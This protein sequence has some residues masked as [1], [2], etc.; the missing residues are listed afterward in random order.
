MATAL[1]T[2]I[3]YAVQTLFD[4]A[5]TAGRLVDLG[6]LAN[7]GLL[8]SFTPAYLFTAGVNGTWYDPSDITTLYRD[9]A[10][11]IPVT[12]MEQPVG[13][14]LDKSKGAVPGANVSD[15]AELTTTGT[16]STTLFTATTAGWYALSANIVSGTG[17]TGW[18]VVSPAYTGPKEAAGNSITA[19]VYVNAGSAVQ[20]SSSSASSLRTTGIAVQALAGNHA[21]NPSGNSA[22]FPVLSARYNLLTKTEDFSDGVWNATSGNVTVS[23]GKII[24]N[25][26]SGGHYVSQGISTLGVTHTITAR[27]KQAGYTWIKLVAFNQYANFDLANGVVGTNYSGVSRTISAVG[28]GSYIC[29]F[30]FTSTSAASNQGCII[31]VGTADNA[32]WDSA[33][34]SGNGVDGIQIYYADLRVANDAL[35]QPAYQRVN[36]S[37]DYDTVGFKPYLKFNGVNQWLQTNSIDFSYTDKM[38]VSVGGR[39]LGT[40]GAAL[41]ELSAIYSTNPAFAV[42]APSTLKDAYGARSRGT[43]TVVLDADGTQPSPVTTVFSVVCSISG[44]L[45]SLRLDGVQDAAST[46][47]QGTGNYGNYPLYIGARAGTSLL[48]NGNLHQLVVA[49]KQASD[50]EIT[51]TE[52]FINQKTG[53]Y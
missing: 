39:K 11:T 35:N 25:A 15:L 22:N 9:A 3:A 38:F 49:G 24:P 47:D 40:S 13:L 26:T 52:T 17:T 28:D 7:Y 33:N 37:T 16:G 29:T 19:I 36:T 4:P 31:K 53:A 1:V 48:F 51:A 45:V 23:S 32:S 42:F 30:T 12:A 20:L 34:Y 6:K 43:A 41:V 14:M 8:T 2:Q 44:P 21:F 50:A 27:V 10:G 5:G 18:S 46:A